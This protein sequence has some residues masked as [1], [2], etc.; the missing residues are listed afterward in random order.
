MKKIKKY[1]TFILIFIILTTI[2]VVSNASYNAPNVS[3]T[4]GENLQITVTSTTFLTS[5]DISLVSYNGL[6]YNS[7][8]KGNDGGGIATV[9][10][11]GGKIS[12]MSTGEGTK[13]LG[14][15]S[16]KAPNVS[17][18]TSYVVKFNVNGD[19][20][21]STVTV[22]PKT[23]SS[24]GGSTSSSGGSSSSSGSNTITSLTV[25]DKTYSNP[26]TD[27]SIG[28]VD[29]TVEN[30]VVKPTT[31]N[32]ASYTINGGSSTTVPL[33]TGTNVITIVVS[34]GKTYKVRVTRLAQEGE[35]QPNII[36]ETEG[37]E[38]EKQEEQENKLTL[39]SL[40]VKNF[41]LDPE[42]N[43]DVYSY[44]INIDMQEK[45][46]DKLDV[47]A[48][49]SASDATVEIIGNE[50]LVEGEN[51]I[52]ILV[53]SADGTESVVYQIIVNKNDA[54]SEIV[55]A[56]VLNNIGFLSNLNPFQKMLVMGFA[57]LVLIIVIVMIII[58]IRK[59]KKKKKAEIPYEG[60]NEQEDIKEE[61][62]F[63]TEE[64][65]QEEQ[66]ASISEE[67][68]KKTELDDEKAKLM[69]EFFSYNQEDDDSIKETKKRNK[70]KGKHF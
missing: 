65:A 43:S 44:T 6:T 70:G 19:T 25:G 18:T 11:G 40:K 5:Y 41:E 22:N 26:N 50:N 46:V 55:S 15:Y 14:T 16:F 20:V 1:I 7:C 28:T 60:I 2:S 61:I 59:N 54:S 36:D 17:S 37:Q 23:S 49:P 24:G 32:G 53:K 56:S 48:I 13:T 21:S 33:K 9:N 34:G 67:T 3:V 62:D 45:N 51:I 66:E 27:I 52:T 12:Y 69:D 38:V 58:L 4:A 47:D 42:F 10:S 29:S 8:S 35:V 39:T 68:M 31:S 57:G 63:G 64:V 30:I